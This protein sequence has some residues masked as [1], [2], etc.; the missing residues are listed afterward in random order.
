[1][2]PKHRVALNRGVVGDKWPMGIL[3]LCAVGSLWMV[4][5][6]RQAQNRSRELAESLKAMDVAESQS[7]E[8][9][10]RNNQII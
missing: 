2:V 9:A 3:W 5:V 10:Y 4:G 1:M 7:G 8:R 6:D